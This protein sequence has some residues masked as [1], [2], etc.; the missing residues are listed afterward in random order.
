[1]RSLNLFLLFFFLITNYSLANQCECEVMECIEASKVVQEKNKNVEI[2]QEIKLKGFL[3]KK[4]GWHPVQERFVSYVIVLEKPV[5]I[6][7]KF[8]GGEGPSIYSRSEI[9]THLQLASVDKESINKNMND[10]DSDDSLIMPNI[11][12]CKTRKELRL[13]QKKITAQRQTTI[14]QNRERILNNIHKM[15]CPRFYTTNTK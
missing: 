9:V 15:D 10:S 2:S 13:K 14:S 11:F 7:G 8:V 4:S 12:R 6:Y 5:C 1:M 3:A